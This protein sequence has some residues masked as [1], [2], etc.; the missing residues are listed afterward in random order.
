M[1]REVDLPLHGRFETDLTVLVSEYILITDN[2][3]KGAA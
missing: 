3:E 1:H 2:E